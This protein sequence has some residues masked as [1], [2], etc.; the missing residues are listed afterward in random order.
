[1]RIIAPF[2]IFFLLTGC[3]YRPASKITQ[4]VLGEKVYVEASISV[5]DPQN[6]VLI[7]DALKEA[8]ISRLG[9]EVVSKNEAHTEVY[10]TLG[11]VGFSPTVYDNDGYV[12][13]YKARVTL[14]LTTRFEDGTQEIVRAAGDYDFSIEPNSV[15]SDT[16]RFE[17]IK[18]ASMDALDE[19]VA[20]ISIKGMRHGKH[21]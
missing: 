14:S 15:I 7:K 8:I 12:I 21:D 9:R 17:A 5:Q 13:A 18:N 20:A 1:M 16:R 19:Y 11:S 3:G 4:A 6:S 10:A 2:L